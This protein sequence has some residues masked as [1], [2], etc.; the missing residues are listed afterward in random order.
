MAAGGKAII[1]ATGLNRQGGRVYE[2]QLRELQGDKWIKVVWEM[3]NQDAVVGAVL[4][5]IEMLIRQV[6]WDVAPATDDERGEAVATFVWECLTDMQVT[7][8]DTL[9]EVLTMLPYGWAYFE[10]VYKRRADGRIGWATW[11]I[12]SQDTLDEWD[13]DENGA[14][15]GLW[16]LPPPDY[17]RRYIPIDKALHFRTS[18]RKGNPE[19]RSI[20][21]TAY[22]SWYFKKHIENIE[23]IGIERDLA[24][25]PVAWVPPDVLLQSTDEDRA[26]YN[27]IKD[28][29][30][31]IR[32]DEQEGVIFPLSYDER[33]NKEFELTLLS[34]GGTRQFDTDKVINRY[35]SRIAMS[36]LADFILLGHE[37]VGSFALSSDKTDLFAV[38]LGAWLDV[39]ASTINQHA[40]PR[41]LKLNGI[42][43][44]LAPTLTYGD[45]EKLGLKDIAD[46]VT[47]ITGAGGVVLD[48][49]Q[50]RWLLERLGMPVADIDT[51]KTEGADD[52]LEAANKDL[53][54]NGAQ[55]TAALAV[56]ERVGLGQLPRENGINALVILF[57]LTIE[58]A[59]QIMGN[60]G[61]GFEMEKPAPTP[62]PAAVPADNPAEEEAANEGAPVKTKGRA[63]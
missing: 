36:M 46:Y 54:L 40:I 9:A 34:T 39:I 63:K 43:P 7:W 16:Q 50:Q 5:A 35:D 1:G 38:A 57:N 42:S 45:I 37:R 11:G 12:R 3:S 17:R 56:V 32:R 31:N 58:Q 53:A 22:R 55:V 15:K 27:A 33:G 48:D 4:F 10:Q 61:K 59:E 18:V 51:G 19:G 24:G 52:G 6:K 25:L 13:F 8:Q 30:T 21:R 20:L 41:L 26:V 23:G 60:V 49:E 2:E 14:I 47:A 62:S 28:I 29:A 44:D